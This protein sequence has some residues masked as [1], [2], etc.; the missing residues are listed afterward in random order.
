M[1]ELIEISNDKAIA[2][3]DENLCREIAKE[4]GFVVRERKF[5]PYDFL[6]ALGKLVT[7]KSPTF[8]DIA[9]L[10]SN[11]VK[12]DEIISKQ[13]VADKF[14]ATT[15]AFLKRILNVMISKVSN[16]L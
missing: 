6:L 7:E 13:A 12:G 11:M 14:N 1:M 16:T 15:I 2:K 10:L 4:T 9:I 8:R 5:S 3:V